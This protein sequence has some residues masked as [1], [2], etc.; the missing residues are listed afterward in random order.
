MLEKIGTMQQN[1]INQ[2][3]SIVIPVSAN[4]EELIHRTIRSLLFQTYP[5]DLYE[6]LIVLD[7]DRSAYQDNVEK[8][9]L[10]YNDPRINIVAKH[11]L[12][13]ERCISRNEGMKAA[14]KDWICWLDSDDE[15]MTSYLGRMN[16]Y[17]NEFPDYKMFNFGAIVCREGG[18][19]L[20]QPVNL[21]KGMPFPEIYGTTG[22]GSFIFKREL[23]DIIGYLPEVMNCYA[24]ADAMNIE[25]YNSKDRTLGNPWGDD[26]AFIYK[27]TRE[28]DSKMVP[29][30][31]YVN[32]IRRS[33]NDSYYPT[34]DSFSKI[35]DKRI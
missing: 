13:Y 24:L 1:T 15:Y 18:Q 27:L 10:S 20:R 28:V 7:G 32:F 34:V 11:R 33:F 30:Y 2:T 25:G 9:I 23:L 16:Y 3:F 19:T 6:I 21:Y 5:P 31:G 35:Y 8:A 29:Y 22:A 26:V 17:I 4:R 12:R 14:T